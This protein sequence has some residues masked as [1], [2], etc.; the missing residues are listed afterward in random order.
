[1]HEAQAADAQGVAVAGG[2]ADTAACLADAAVVVHC[3]QVAAEA[4]HCEQDV[5]DR[6]HVYAAASLARIVLHVRFK[7]RINSYWSTFLLARPRWI[8]TSMAVIYVQEA[9]LWGLTAY[10][11]KGRWIVDEIV[12]G[13]SSAECEVEGGCVVADRGDVV[14]GDSA[15]GCAR[16]SLAAER[17]RWPRK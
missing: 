9:V 14:A 10:G 8:P 4:I 5:S 3:R 17:R 12:P 6:R 7:R 2:E 16:H 11:D 15:G 1:M 13:T